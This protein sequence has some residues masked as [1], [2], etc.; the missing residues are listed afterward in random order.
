MAICLTNAADKAAQSLEI[1]IIRSS[2]VPYHV[3]AVVT[4]PVLGEQ[5]IDALIDSGSEQVAFMHFEEL[6]IA[7]GWTAVKR[8][9]YC[10]RTPWSPEAEAANL[11]ALAIEKAEHPEWF[12][13]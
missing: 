6:V 9:A 4:S 7:L 3:H 8:P 12:A 5:T 11:A 2:M 10:S 1:K 13:S